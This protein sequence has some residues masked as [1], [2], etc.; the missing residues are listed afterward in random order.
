MKLISLNIWGGRQLKQLTDYVSEKANDTDIFC[1]QEVFDTPTDKTIIQEHYRADILKQ[2]K[3]VLPNHTAYFASVQ[4]KMEF[5]NTVNYS[6][7]WGVAMFI[8]NTINAKVND[9]MIY[10]ERNSIESHG[11]TIPRNLQYAHLK[12]NNQ[13]YVIAHF[14]GLW[15][16]K[17]KTDTENRINQSNKVKEFLNKEEG[18]IILCGDF[19][20]LPDTKSLAI[21]E[22]NMINLIKAHNITSTRSVLYTKPDKYADYAIVSKDV[23]VLNFNVPNINASD[24]LPLELDFN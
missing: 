13:P 20:Y 15:N 24:H 6:I 7:D 14:H 4:D 5:G 22:E 21:L 10:R 17:G 1:F 12:I 8:K 11:S 18:K 16:G 2:L 19:N 3:K 9:I 23:N